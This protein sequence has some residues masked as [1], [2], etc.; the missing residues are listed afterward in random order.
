MV[1]TA[2]DRIANITYWRSF[3]DHERSHSI[4][5]FSSRFEALA[6]MCSNPQELG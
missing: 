3:E 5:T 2:N 4:K 1:D 6:R